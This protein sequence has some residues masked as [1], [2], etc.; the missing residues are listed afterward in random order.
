MLIKS[1]AYDTK[2][3]SKYLAGA[4]P[5]ARVRLVTCSN[6]VHERPSWNHNSEG[7]FTC[8]VEGI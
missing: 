5:L 8:C 2:S 4:L 7:I 3:R 6:V 1:V